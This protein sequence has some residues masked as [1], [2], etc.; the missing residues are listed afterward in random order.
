MSAT[1]AKKPMKKSVP[2][3]KAAEK[4]VAKAAPAKVAK[5]TKVAVKESPSK[6]KA[7]TKAKSVKPVAAVAQK[8]SAKKVAAPV[9]K[10]AKKPVKK[11]VVAEAKKPT[12]AVVVAETKKSV[13]AAVAAKAAEKPAKKDS[14]K[15]KQEKTAPKKAKVVADKKVQETAA[16]PALDLVFKFAEKRKL[17]QLEAERKEAEGRIVIK[18][19]RRPTTRQKGTNS[20]SF[21]P[22][23][24]ESFRKI[25]LA[26]RNEAIGQSRSLRDNALEQTE[27][28]SREDDDGSDVTIRLQSLSQVDV[29]SKDIQKIDEALRRI[30]NG[31][32]GICEECGQLIRKQRLAHM[33]IAR[34]CIEC[35]QKIEKSG[36]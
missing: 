27:D 8:P 30:D 24:L 20:Q 5:S 12:K 31:T 32:F 28:R 34:H 29:K 1:K 22:A 10:V 4:V 11:A 21:P 9:E 3:K 13:K 19:G 6:K 35:Q 14:P 15:S 33:P 7:E 25:L 2:A 16:N 17:E 36:R 23:D 18:P 26:I